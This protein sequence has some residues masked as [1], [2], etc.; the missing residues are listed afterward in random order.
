[1]KDQKI[2]LTIATTRPETIFDS[3]ICINPKWMKVFCLLKREKSYQKIPFLW[4]AQVWSA[5][6][7][8]D[9]IEFGTGCKSDSRS[10]IWTQNAI[11]E[12]LPTWNYWHLCE[13]AKWN[14][15]GLHYHSV[16]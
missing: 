5:H 11:R 4:V 16:L 15:F 3:V 8:V 7:Y 1:M 14:S 12:K 9:I 13:D 10:P 6:E 2:S